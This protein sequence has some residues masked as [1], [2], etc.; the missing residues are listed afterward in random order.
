MKQIKLFQD[1][2]F[3]LVGTSDISPN[4][5]VQDAEGTAATRTTDSDPSVNDVSHVSEEAATIVEI[6]GYASVFLNPDGTRLEDRDGESVSI[7]LLDIDNYTNNPILVYNHDWGDVTG[8][9]TFIEKRPAGLYIKAEVH[10]FTGRE[11]VFEAVQR[12]VIKTFSIGF[13]PKTFNYIESADILEITE[14]ELVEISLAPVPANQDAIFTV[15]GQKS[16]SVSTKTVKAQNDMT[17]DELNGICKL[18]KTKGK[19]MQTKDLSMEEK[20]KQEA[21]EKAKQEAEEKA[22]QEAEENAKQEAEENAKQEAE[23]KAKQEASKPNEV[24]VQELAAQFVQAQQEA[25]QEAAEQRV[26]DAL[27]Y[28]AE[29]KEQI[30][31]TDASE[32][33]AEELDAFYELLTTTSEVIES[34]IIEAV[35]ANAA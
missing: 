28:I 15:T 16:I 30:L 5:V 14:A 9:V 21:E 33:D 19:Q 8:R 13:I 2:G 25:D 20:A 12:G 3:K 26:A 24:S 11:Q 1:V 18:Q 7:A 6:E 35:K 27:A 34:K 32:I 10:K 23:E 31:N 17:C 29:Q 4:K 22:K